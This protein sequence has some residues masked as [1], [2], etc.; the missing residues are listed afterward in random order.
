MADRFEEARPRLS[1]LKAQADKCKETYKRILSHFNHA[2]MKSSEFVLLWDDFFIPP[3]LVVNK[4]LAFQRDEIVPNFCKPHVAPS[5]D[6][7][8][9][10][11]EIRTPQQVGEAVA[12]R[13]RMPPRRK[14]R[15][16]RTVADTVAVARCAW[17][18]RKRASASSSSLA[19]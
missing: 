13:K 17:H 12:K 15:A 9:V 10:L 1:K 2:G 3:D 14:S 11:W 16:H 19:A 8:M 5:V 4:P 6:S 18:W 7:L